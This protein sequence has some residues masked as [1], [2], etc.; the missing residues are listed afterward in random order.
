MAGESGFQ[1]AGDAAASYERAMSVFMAPWSSDLIERARLG[2]GMDVLDVACGTGFAA[3]RAR[4][5]VGDT[6]RVVGVDINPQMV[7]MAQRVTGLEMHEAPADETGLPTAAFD[8]AVCQQSLQFFPDP[9]AALREM[10]RVLRPGGRVVVSVWE[11]FDS[12]PYFRSQLRFLGPHLSED[13]AAAYRASDITALGGAGALQAL[14]E[15]AGFRDVAA[16]CCTLPVEFPPMAEFVPLHAAAL[17]MGSAFHAL[18]PAQKTE[19]IHR[20]SDELDADDPDSAVA[21]PMLS[22]VATA[23]TGPP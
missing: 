3:R 18:P 5:V 23:A 11:D 17:P 22:W 12:N 19:I 8:V 10:G 1:V 4:E 13:D 9:A 20:M 16:E 2:P 6:G 15:N 7:T 21:V 14:L